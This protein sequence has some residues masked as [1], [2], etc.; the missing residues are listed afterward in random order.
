M[1][2]VGNDA[3]KVERQLAEGVLACPGCGAA[4]R[5]WGHARARD[6]RVPGG[7]SWRVR[8]RRAA[9][10]ACGTT[11]VLLPAAMLARRADSA[12][13]IGTALAGAAAGAGHGR[14]AARLGVAA[15]TVRGWLRRFASRAEALRSAFTV[16]AC[17]LD[18]DPLLPGPAGSPLADAVAAILAAC[19]AAARRWGAAVSALSPWELASA[20]TGGLL[21]GP[22]TAVQLINTS[23]PW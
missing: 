21:L 13:V 16:L 22:G 18:P 8:P 10:P 17:A 12:A 15:A 9:C 23:C 5:R 7:K 11:H 2:T 4:L 3:A 20:V 19:A 6:V 14:L 1:L